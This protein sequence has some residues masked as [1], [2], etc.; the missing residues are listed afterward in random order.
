MDYLL[1]PSFL[2]PADSWNSSF[3]RSIPVHCIVEQV[4]PQGQSVNLSQ[5]AVDQDSFAIIPSNALFSEIVHTA[6]SKL[7]YSS[8]AALTAKGAIQL[9]NWK[10]LSFD[11]ITESPEATVG[12]ILGELSSAATLRIRLYSRPKLHSANDVKKNYYK[13]FWL[14]PRTSWSIPVA[15]STRWVTY[16]ILSPL[17]LMIIFVY[18][19]QSVLQALT[20]GRLECDIPDETRKKFDQWYLQQ[21]FQHC[22]QVALLQQQ[23]QQQQQQ[24]QQQHLHHHHPHHPAIV[25]PGEPITVSGSPPHSGPQDLVSRVAIA[26][27]QS[28]GRTRIRTS[29][30]PE[31]ELPKLH[32]W[33]AENQH[34]SRLQIQQYGERTNLWI[35]KRGAPKHL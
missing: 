19:L 18:H 24:Q 10:P 15:R 11:Q 33:F 32:R 4:T 5:A 28:Q 13:S 29:F 9:K 2:P 30:D 27:P 25:Q 14:N 7:G 21:F 31:L 16:E 23:H 6:L 1:P 20:K 8:S 26:G 17:L 35:P 34:P 3:G 12:D 22:R